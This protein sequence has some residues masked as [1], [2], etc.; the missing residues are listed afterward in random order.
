M[1]NMLALDPESVEGRIAASEDDR[2]KLKA[3]MVK[4]LALDPESVD[5]RIAASEY[6]REKVKALLV[7]DPG[8]ASYDHPPRDDR[9]QRPEARTF[10]SHGLFEDD[11]TRSPTPTATSPAHW[12]GLLGDP[13]ED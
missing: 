7:R 10:D 6:D 5:G 12:R 8:R 2:D 1:A 3:R 4:M 9:G 13:P 11:P